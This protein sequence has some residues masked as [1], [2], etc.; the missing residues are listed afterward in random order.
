MARTKQVRTLSFTLVI[1]QEKK[2][3]REKLPWLLD[4]VS[5]AE[6]TEELRN[7]SS[8]VSLAFDRED[9]DVIA[10]FD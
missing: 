1:H 2:Y 3:S 8:F 10:M 4:G 7:A 5:F 6:V 9:D